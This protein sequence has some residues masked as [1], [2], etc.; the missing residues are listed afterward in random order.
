MS[1]THWEEQIQERLD[2]E[3]DGGAWRALEGHL[4]ECESC[5][6]FDDEMRAL[7]AWA[8]GLPV[9]SP[10]AHFADAVMARIE[11]ERAPALWQAALSIALPLAIMAV[12]AVVALPALLSAAEAARGWWSSGVDAANSY[13]GAMAS[14]LEE[15]GRGL[16]GTVEPIPNPFG[17]LQGWLSGV[18]LTAA[19]G[20]AF[21]IVLAMNFAHA[22]AWVR[23]SV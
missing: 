7:D 20:L 5:A 17:A 16:A 1:C 10:G 22:R 4:A 21:L 11:E 19:A 23:S 15:A 6:R 9:E 12:V 18:W 14:N 3:L 2:G 8:L 13:A